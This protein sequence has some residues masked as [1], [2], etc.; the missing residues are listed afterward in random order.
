MLYQKCIERCI[1][2]QT[3][4]AHVCKTDVNE[5]VSVIVSAQCLDSF[6]K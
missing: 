3:F 2:K 4:K 5:S 1:Y 6:A